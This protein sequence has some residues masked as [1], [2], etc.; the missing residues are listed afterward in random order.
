MVGALLGYSVEYDVFGR[1][2]AGVSVDRFID[3][4]VDAAMALAEAPPTRRERTGRDED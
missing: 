2:P 1:Q 3:A 4:V